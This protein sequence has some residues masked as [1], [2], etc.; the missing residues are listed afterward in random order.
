MHKDGEEN[1]NTSEHLFSLIAK[2]C[3]GLPEMY[4]RKPRILETTV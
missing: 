2:C 3:H 1:R 4:H